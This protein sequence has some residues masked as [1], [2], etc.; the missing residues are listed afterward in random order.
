MGLLDSIKKLLSPPDSNR[1]TSSNIYGVSNSNSDPFEKSRD[2]IK[3]ATSYK[4]SDISKA[5]A[6]TQEAINVCPETILGD[7]FKLANYYH[8]ASEI[9]RAH[10]I[11]QSLLVG[12]SKGDIGMYNMNQ[13]LIYEKICAMAYKDK[14]YV[15]YL[16]NYFFWLYHRTLAFAC[17]G[18]KEELIG[19]LNNPTKL[20]YLAPTKVNG[21]FKKLGKLEVRE[22]FNA[23]VNEFLNESK[24]T[25]NEMVKKS[26][27]AMFSPSNSTYRMGESVGE[28]GNRLLAKDQ[29]FM[30]NYNFANEKTRIVKFFEEKLNAKIKN[31]PQQ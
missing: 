10:D 20:D 16:R 25:F 1:S 3:E 7:Y 30:K 9:E 19:I 5:I 26:Y 31:M 12:L 18:R 29:V 17:Q 27:K 13:S 23:L 6:L 11:F 2:L 4:K 21:C 24:G 28:R 8:I 14:D 15:N 22:D